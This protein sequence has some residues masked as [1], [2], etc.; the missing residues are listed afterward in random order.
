MSEDLTLAEHQQ[1]SLAKALAPTSTDEKMPLAEIIENFEHL[2]KGKGTIQLEKLLMESFAPKEFEELGLSRYFPKINRGLPRLYHRDHPSTSHIKKHFTHLPTLRT[3][4]LDKAIFSLYGQ[5]Q[6]ERKCTL[7]VFV[8]VINDGLSDYAAASEACRILKERF[9]RADVHL[10]ALADAKTAL[11]PVEGVEVHPV[12]YT[13]EIGPDLFPREILE[14][15]RSSDLILQLPSFYPFTRELMEAVERIDSNL[16]M[17]KMELLGEYGFL[18]SIWFH[19][20]TGNRS[21]GLHFLEKG[22]LVHK[23]SMASFAEVENRALLTGLFGT[24]APGPAEIEAYH[25][26]HQFYLASLA[27]PFG[28]AVYLHALLKAQEHDSRTIDICTPDLNWFI[29]YTEMQNAQG[30][31]ILDR[32]LG[33]ASIEVA[34]Q[35]QSYAVATGAEGK[36]LRLF[37]PGAI[38]QKDFRALVSLSGEF[39]G[40]R[41]DQSFSEAVSTNRVFFYDGREHARYFLKDLAALAENRIAAHRSALSCF[42]GMG[43]AFLHHLPQQEGEWVDETFFQ[44]KEDWLEI[45]FQIGISLQDPDAVAGFK[46]LNRIIAE[47][48]SCNEFLSHLVQRSVCHRQNP[49]LAMEEAELLAAFGSKEI[50]FPTLVLELK[51]LLTPS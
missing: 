20:K 21:M 37:S 10:V 34:W 13:S 47:E 22:I 14:R 15:L 25:E 4:A 42:R 35:G 12:S 32:S 41:G 45:A 36:K 26:A 38:S 40:V 49:L 30:K 9:H 51:G 16:P 2:F 23:A 18:E 39:V 43:K 17:P 28:G 33:V 8:W 1:E 11:P 44:E 31:P 24:E 50:S 19:P 3:L 7:S 6:I 27:T 48:Y 29:Q 46:K 5:V